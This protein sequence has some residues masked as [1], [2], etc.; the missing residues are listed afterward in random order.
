MTKGTVKFFNSQKGY[1]FILQPDSGGQDV[2]SESRISRKRG[3]FATSALNEL[4]QAGNQQYHP[5]ASSV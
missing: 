3:C 1:G 4:G 2:P 5:T